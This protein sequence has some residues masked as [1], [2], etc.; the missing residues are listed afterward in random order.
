MNTQFLPWATTISLSLFSCTM[1]YL[2]ISYFW[3]RHSRT[4]VQPSGGEGEESERQLFSGKV[5]K[6]TT[7]TQQNQS[8]GRQN[9][10]QNLFGYLKSTIFGF[11]PRSLV[12]CGVPPPPPEPQAYPVG[13]RPKTK[14]ERNK[15]GLYPDY[16]ALSGVPWP[17]PYVD[18][19]PQRALPRPYRPFRW[20]YHQIMSIYNPHP[21]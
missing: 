17:E 10:K 18:F 3:D 1:L 7:S 9:K 20:P 12:E 13:F 14:A 5:E 19:D 6:A 21:P 11:A 8:R 15:L 2:A 4:A 16:A